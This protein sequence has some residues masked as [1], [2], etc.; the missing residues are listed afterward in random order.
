LA[1]PTIRFG[2][3]FECSGAG[4]GGVGG[5]G[6]STSTHLIQPF[7]NAAL[8][9]NLDQIMPINAYFWKK[10]L[11]AGGLASTLL[12]SPTVIAFVEHVSCIKRTLLLR[13]VT[14]VHTVNIL[15]LRFPHFRVY[16]SLRTLQ[17]LLV[18]SLIS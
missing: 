15:I 9:R 12:L 10:P 6:A 17:I 18:G 1:S 13:K 7:K 4:T 14:E 16:F 5:E 8:S 11:A 3:Y 2:P